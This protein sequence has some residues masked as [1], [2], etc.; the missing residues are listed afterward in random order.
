MVGEVWPCHRPR[1]DSAA[2][3]STSRRGLPRRRRD[4]RQQRPWAEGDG[5]PPRHQRPELLPARRLG[6]RQ[7]ARRQAPHRPPGSRARVSTDIWSRCA[8]TSC[9]QML[10]PVRPPRAQSARHWR[11]DAGTCQADA[12]RL[13]SPTTS[14]REVRG[15]LRNRKKCP[16]SRLPLRTP[17]LKNTA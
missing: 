13:W 3:R 11:R 14:N 1:P 10:D 9:A 16:R 15:A 12:L 17:S 7:E 2:P 5:H 8:P 6:A 4:T